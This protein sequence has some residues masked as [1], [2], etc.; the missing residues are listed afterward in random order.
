[1]GK[2]SVTVKERYNNKVYDKILIRTK[3]AELSHEQIKTA[4]AHSG[5]SLNSFIVQAIKE[6]IER[7]PP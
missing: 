7:G 1:M 2:T 6:K 3:K 5:E 4:A